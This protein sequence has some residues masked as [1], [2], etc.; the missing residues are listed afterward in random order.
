MRVLLA[1]IAATAAVLAIGGTA[2][3]EGDLSRT[4]VKEIVLEMGSN[5]D[6]MYFSPKRMEF[7]TGQAYKMVMTNV[8]EIKHE[9]ALGELYEKIFTRK[10]EI[11]EPDGSLIAE[12]KGPIYEIEIGPG[13]TVEWFF[14]PVQTIEDAELICAIPGHKEAGM[15]STVT[16]K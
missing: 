15:W 9:V 2:Y 10:L 6:G 11:T 1:S 12:I 5:D 13:K 4:N 16:L 7:E 3:A 8:D 14:V